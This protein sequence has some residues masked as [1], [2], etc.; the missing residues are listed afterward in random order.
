MFMS[1]IESLDEEIEII[2][3]QKMLPHLSAL[4]SHVSAALADNK[5]LAQALR[6][7]TSTVA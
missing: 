1:Q 7:R 4:A 6:A 5:H 3:V 2:C